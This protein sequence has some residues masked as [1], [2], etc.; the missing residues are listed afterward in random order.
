[1]AVAGI[2][3]TRETVLLTKQAAGCTAETLRAYRW[4]LARLL[5]YPH[6]FPLN[7]AELAAR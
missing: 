1:L 4:W 2:D 3:S 5:E 6:G 7:L